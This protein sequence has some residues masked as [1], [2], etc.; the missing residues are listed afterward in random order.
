MTEPFGS[1]YA[2]CYDA[3]YTEK[4]YEAECDLIEKLLRNYGQAKMSSILDLGCG[5]GNH[6]LPLARRG[7][8]VVGVDRSEPMLERARSKAAS[9]GPTCHAEF[10]HADIRRVDL[11]RRFDAA[12]MMFAVLGYQLAN[13]DVIAALRAAR[14]HLNPGGLLLFDVWHGP[15]VLLQRPSERLRVIPM[16]DGKILR[17]AASELDTNRHICTVRYHLWTC[18]EGLLS[19]TD[20]EHIMRYFFPLEL[21]LFL[22]SAGFT[23]IRLG[24]FPEFDRVPDE[25]TWNALCVARAVPS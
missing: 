20:E 13:E 22:E 16:A 18:A 11:G 23:A 3:L 8:A 12:L 25:N 17:T 5:T 1:D 21:D 6:A 19:E 24:A 7:F 2:K 4:D 9:S 15:A 10:Y 14:R